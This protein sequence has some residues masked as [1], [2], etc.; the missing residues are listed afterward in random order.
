MLKMDDEAERKVG[1]CWQEAITCSHCEYFS[2]RDKLYEEVDSRRRGRK[3]AD[4]NRAIQIGLTHTPMANT[5]LQA[6]LHTAD[7]LAP[8][9]SGLQKQANPV[10]NALIEL[11]KKD[12]KMRR[13]QIKDLNE[14]K[15]LPPD[16]AIRVEGDSR[17]NSP[18]FAGTSKTPFQ[19]ASQ[20]VYTICENVTKKNIISVATE[21]KLCHAGALGARKSG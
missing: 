1:L 16:A 17:Y 14:L 21:Y 8:S 4:L 13:E 10:N 2:G 15:D 6:L 12:M 18:L 19:P 3:P 7:I 11:N 20:V 5:G 9:L